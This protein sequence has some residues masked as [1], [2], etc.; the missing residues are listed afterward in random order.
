[1][2]VADGE[3]NCNCCGDRWTAD[4][5]CWLLKKYALGAQESFT[6]P[7]TDTDTMGSE[8]AVVTQLHPPQYPDYT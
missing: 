4:H 1:M 8:D 5:D 7:W 2:T 3:G 6:E